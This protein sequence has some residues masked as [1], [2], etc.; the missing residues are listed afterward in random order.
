MCRATSR[1][2]RATSFIAAV[3]RVSL[4][5][6]ARRTARP[7]TARRATSAADRSACARIRPRR[8]A[9]ACRSCS[10]SAS[11]AFAVSRVVRAIDEREQRAPLVDL[12][13]VELV[14]AV[15]AIVPSALDERIDALLDVA[16]RI[17]DRASTRR[18]APSRAAR[19]RRCSPTCRSTTAVRAHH[20]FGDSDR[21]WL[22]SLRAR[23]RES[24]HATIATAA[25][26]H[27]T[28]R[29]LRGH[30][31]DRTSVDRRAARVEA[32][33]MLDHVA[34]RHV[35]EVAVDHADVLDRRV[36]EAAEIERRTGSSGS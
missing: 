3:S 22:R 23:R 10:R 15:A 11:A 16:S 8:C 20:R 26:A 32:A 4:R 31:L 30:H 13:E 1:N 34:L 33:D 18:R 17:S 21:P 12:V 2:W 9:A 24:T 27:A 7:C 19:A 29:Q 35:V 6:L 25:T 28:V 14:G 5:V 36:R